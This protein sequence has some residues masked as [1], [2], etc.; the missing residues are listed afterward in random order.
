MTLEILVNKT[1]T[2]IDDSTPKQSIAN[3]IWAI[4]KLTPRAPML[5]RLLPTLE[6]AALW[7]AKDFNLQ[8]ASNI[9]W[10]AAVL[11]MVRRRLAVDVV[12]TLIEPILQQSEKLVPQD[13]SN[14]L[15]AATS[16]EPDVQALLRNS[17]PILLTG[18]RE[19]LDT[20]AP[21]AISN[22]IWAVGIL[23]IVDEEVNAFL[24]PALNYTSRNLH[25]FE[26]RGLANL[27][28]GLAL[29]AYKDTSF[30]ATVSVVVVQLMPRWKKRWARS[31]ELDL[32]EFLWAF[33]KFDLRDDNLMVTCAEQ[34]LPRVAKLSDWSLC[35]LAWSLQTTNPDSSLHHFTEIVWKEIRRRDFKESDVER[36]SK[37]PRLW[38]DQW[39]GQ[40]EIR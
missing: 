17:A 3:M 14:L 2:L 9:V 40:K 24:M 22:I 29:C 26:P 39:Q 6:D 8:E 37:G 11:H 23:G 30:M 35:A 28:L 36:S 25:A 16:L 31:I 7:W 12:P 32:V 1:V 5:Q 27:C 19:K 38:A 18:I 4:A 21:Q 34:L 10:G 20:A 33:A 15:W 13:V